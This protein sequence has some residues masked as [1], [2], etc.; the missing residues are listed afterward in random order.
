M[1]HRIDKIKS[2]QKRV[3]VCLDTCH[4]FAAGYPLKPKNLLMTLS[5]NSM[6][7]LVFLD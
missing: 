3:A 4:V 7:Q 6:T 2:L 5:N 1:L